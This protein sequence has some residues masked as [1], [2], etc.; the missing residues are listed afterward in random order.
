[1]V[2]RARAKQSVGPEMQEIVMFK[3]RT[4]IWVLE[5]VFGGALILLPLM[6]LSLCQVNWTCSFLWTMGLFLI[7][8]GVI[9]VSCAS[10]MKQRMFLAKRVDMLA[11][12]L[13]DSSGSSDKIG[14]K[15]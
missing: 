3:D 5:Y 14:D 13:A 6:G 2:T 9:L 4:V 11:K 10:S 12:Q 8:L 15:E 1:M 7:C